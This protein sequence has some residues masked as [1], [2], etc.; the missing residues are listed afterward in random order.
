[1]GSLGIVWRV[2]SHGWRRLRH[3]FEQ[4]LHQGP[5][6]APLRPVGLWAATG[7]AGA[8]ALLIQ[9]LESSWPLP[10][11]LRQCEPQ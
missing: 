2:V 6:L 8:T 9:C 11:P 1:M 3:G 10:V 7:P 4:G 5:A